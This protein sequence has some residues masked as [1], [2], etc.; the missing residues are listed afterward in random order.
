M[1]V[2]ILENF[3]FALVFITN[4]LKKKIKKGFKSY[5]SIIK[6]KKL[7][8]GILKIEITFKKISE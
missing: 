4:V 7:N 8:I 3:G 5:F 2:E 1:I 6:S